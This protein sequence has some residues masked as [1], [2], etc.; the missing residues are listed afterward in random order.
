MTNKKNKI[1]AIAAMEYRGPIPPPKLFGQ[2][3]NIL[4]G[5]ADRILKMA[6]KQSEHRHSLEKQHVDRSLKDARTGLHYG[7]IIVI[8]CLLISGTLL[9]IDKTTSGLILGG[10]SLASLAAVFVYGTRIKK[11]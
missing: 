10:G 4:S 9:F 5:A 6:E 3:E 8:F 7:F 2:Y 1:N 11:T